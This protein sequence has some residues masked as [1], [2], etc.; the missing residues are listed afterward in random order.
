MKYCELLVLDAIYSKPYYPNDRKIISYLTSKLCFEDVRSRDRDN[1]D[2]DDEDGESILSEATFRQWLQHKKSPSRDAKTRERLL[3]KKYRA[4]MQTCIESWA[5]LFYHPNVARSIDASRN[6][7]FW[8][9]NKK[10]SMATFWESNHQFYN[11][12]AIF[13]IA[14]EPRQNSFNLSIYVYIFLLYSNLFLFFFLSSRS[15]FFL[16]SNVCTVFEDFVVNFRKN[17]E[18]VFVEL[19]NLVRNS[20]NLN[21]QHWGLV[22]G[23]QRIVTH[24]LVEDLIHFIGTVER[25]IPEQR[26]RSSYENAKLR[27]FRTLTSHEV[28]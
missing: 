24:T 18:D 28:L 27:L 9:R 20:S 13:G 10:S 21:I 12:E 3:T 11:E 16:K 22:D 19:S 1:E 6:K 8:M 14:N 5:S 26:S 23:G 17:V 2:P 25:N 4:L 15:E 7:K